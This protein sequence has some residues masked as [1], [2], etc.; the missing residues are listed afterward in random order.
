MKYE[1]SLYMRY[2]VVSDVHGYYT[3]LRN[4]L[5]RAG[6]FSDTKESRLVVCGDAFDRGEQAKELQAF[7][8]EL[9]EQNRLI[10]ILGNHE[11]LLVKCMQEISRGKIFEIACGMSHHNPNGTWD[12]LLQLGEM[13]EKEAVLNPAELLRRVMRTPFYKKLLPAGVDF[14][15][16]ENH[17]FCHGWIPTRAEYDADGVRYRYDE[18]WRD[19]EVGVWQRARWLNGMDMAC[20]YGIKESG[21][22]VVCGHWH[23]SYGHSKINKT[24]SEWGD[25]ADFSP[26]YSDGIIA[27]DA[28]TAYSRTVNCVV[29]EDGECKGKE[30]ENKE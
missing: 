30:K 18:N 19:A 17:I 11:D 5:E 25:D 28:C 13:S 2:Y 24:C 3:E 16:S 26:F 9:L 21:K 10:Y 29:I 6:F 4:A 12:T 7:L 20:R 8:T 27:I 23:A 22:T 15:E 1:R 14:H